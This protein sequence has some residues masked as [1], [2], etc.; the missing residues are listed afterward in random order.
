MLPPLRG[1]VSARRPSLTSCPF[2]TE[3]Y[4]LLGG[5]ALGPDGPE[6]LALVFAHRTP[7][8]GG[9]G[10]LAAIP[11]MLFARGNNFFSPFSDIVPNYYTLPI[12]R[13]PIV[14]IC[15]DYAFVGHKILLDFSSL[16]LIHTIH[17]AT[18][19][20]IQIEMTS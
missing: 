6:P 1:D 11:E 19:S 2:H 5:S 16:L 13:S 9:Y 15:T 10:E 4:L 7:T 18:V 12:R 8:I 17:A 14:L 20:L 3:C